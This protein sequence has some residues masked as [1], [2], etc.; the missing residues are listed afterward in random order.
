M[1]SLN[2][3]RPQG[4]RWAHVVVRK[5]NDPLVSLGQTNDIE[6][7]WRCSRSVLSFRKLLRE[8]VHLYLGER[9]SA[10][11]IGT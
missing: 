1:A 2:P 4:E 5:E 6:R 8:R 11:A 9:L 10:T 7:F 3:L